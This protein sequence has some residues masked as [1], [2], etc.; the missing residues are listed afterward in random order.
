MCHCFL[1]DDIG[2]WQTM[3]QGFACRNLGETE[4]WLSVDYQI[5]CESD[6]YLAFEIMCSIGVLAVP[7][8]IPGVSLL[9]LIKNSKGI[10]KG[11][12]NPSFDRYEFLVADY[13]REF[14]FFDCLGAM[15]AARR[16]PPLPF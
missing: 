14:F 10:M 4:S 9:V 12:G 13:R 15:I 16:A 1:S 6:V 11:P 8:G 5:S 2:G 3:F 7:I